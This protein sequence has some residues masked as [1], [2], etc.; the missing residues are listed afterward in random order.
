[1]SEGLF[2]YH[3]AYCVLI[4]MQNKNNNKKKKERYSVGS[5]CY[6]FYLVTQYFKSVTYLALKTSLSLSPPHIKSNVGWH[7]TC[8]T[9]LCVHPAKTQI[10][11]LPSEDSDQFA[12]GQSKQSAVR[13]K[14]LCVRACVHVCV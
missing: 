1:M 5:H 8:P 14:M 10:S 7:V 6:M 3:A 4:S 13:L 12:V 2:S 9:G 11:L